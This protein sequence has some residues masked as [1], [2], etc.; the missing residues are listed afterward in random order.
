M[1]EKGTAITPSTQRQPQHDLLPGYAPSTYDNVIC[2]ILKNCGTINFL[3]N[4]FQ[5]PPSF[6]INEIENNRNDKYFFRGS[7]TCSYDLESLRSHVRA[8]SNI[9]V[10]SENGWGGGGPNFPSL[11]IKINPFERRDVSDQCSENYFVLFWGKV[12]EKQRRNGDHYLTFQVH[13]L[14]MLTGGFSTFQRA[15][16]DK[17][18]L[19]FIPCFTGE[20]PN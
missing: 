15:V 4:V 13:G 19:R 16:C 12:I 2:E 7:L 10:Y 9:P 3:R 11:N 1:G 6:H 20:W 18:P 14:Q 8:G 17:W 5:D